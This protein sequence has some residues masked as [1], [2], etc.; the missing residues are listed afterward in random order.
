ML[1]LQNFQLVWG[2]RNLKD[3]GPGRYTAP[4]SHFWGGQ[5]KKNM[6]SSP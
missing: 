4:P 5:S 3:L 1:L 6:F 2:M